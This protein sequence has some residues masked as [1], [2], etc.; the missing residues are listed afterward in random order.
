MA[1]LL[2]IKSRLYNESSFYKLSIKISSL[3]LIKKMKKLFYSFSTTNKSAPLCTTQ[4]HVRSYFV[5]SK[6]SGNAH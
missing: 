3:G 4:K 1:V 5:E 2:N 6:I